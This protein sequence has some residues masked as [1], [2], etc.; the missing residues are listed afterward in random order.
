LT[1]GNLQRR[2]GSTTS[3][4]Y[5][6]TDRKGLEDF[7][8]PR[9]LTEP[10]WSFEL[11]FE[12]NMGWLGFLW[13]FG[14]KRKSFAQHAPSGTASLRLSPGG[15]LLGYRGH[16]PARLVWV[17]SGSLYIW[18]TICTPNCHWAGGRRRLRR[19]PPTNA[20][21]TSHLLFTTV[22]HLSPTSRS[23]RCHVAVS[24]HST[25]FLGATLWQLQEGERMQTVSPAQA[26]CEVR[27]KEA[28][29]EASR[30]VSRVKMN[31]RY[32]L[33]HWAR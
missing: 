25:G 16:G 7:P 14:S 15:I 1:R 8:A 6:L 22:L 20:R 3:S 18:T 29:T 33:P 4:S 31:G 10:L 12:E 27:R 21:P 23:P 17:P 26:L 5:V 24:A 13:K 30:R 2:Q 28:E 19:V 11:R 32:R 9:P